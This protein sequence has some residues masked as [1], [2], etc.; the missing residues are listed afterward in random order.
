MNLDLPDD[1]IRRAILDA[2]VGGRDGYSR[3]SALGQ[4]ARGILT[5]HAPALE[6]LIAER[7]AAVLAA[8]ETGAAIDAAV[9]E[10][11]AQ[12]AH[13]EAERLAKK[14]VRKAAEA[15]ELFKP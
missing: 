11:F 5:K 4:A 2:L 10:T 9:R 12:A 13:A 8:P 7:F 1:A 14:H 6:K 15:A 3:E